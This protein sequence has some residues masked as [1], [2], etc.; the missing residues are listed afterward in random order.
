[1]SCK[2]DFSLVQIPCSFKKGRFLITLNPQKFFLAGSN[3]KNHSFFISLVM[4]N[5]TMFWVRE[6][7]YYPFP[8]TEI[9]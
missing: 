7:Q 3:A 9:L 1:M 8:N 6:T 4:F 2:N 5:L